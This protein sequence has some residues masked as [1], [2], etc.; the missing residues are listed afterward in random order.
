MVEILSNDCQVIVESLS[1]SVQDETR[2]HGLLQ[3]V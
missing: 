1:K 2:I 3:A